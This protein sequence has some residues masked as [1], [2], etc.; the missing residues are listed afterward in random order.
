[1]TQLTTTEC[2]TLAGV[3]PRTI[4]RK[5]NAGKL[6]ASMGEDGNYTVDAAEFYRVYPNATTKDK[7]DKKDATVN[8]NELMECRAEI[9]RL[10]DM[11]RMLTDK[12]ELL[13]NTIEDYKSRESKLMEM[14]NSTTKLLTYTAQNKKKKGWFRK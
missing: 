1:M 2:A 11:C 5:I 13:S 6:S 8:N 9:K 12:V 10:N 7:S 3:A 14:A 4:Q